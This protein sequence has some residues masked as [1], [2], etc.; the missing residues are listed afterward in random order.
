MLGGLLK[1]AGGNSPRGLPEQLFFMVSQ[2]PVLL[3]LFLQNDESECIW[4]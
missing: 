3:C 2:R 1:L 4:L